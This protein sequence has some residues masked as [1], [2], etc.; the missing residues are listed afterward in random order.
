MPPGRPT[1]YNEEILV[2][3]RAY[4]DG[5]YLTCGDVIPQMAG[6][7]IELDIHRD[8]IYDWCDDPEKQAFSD[9]VAKCLRAQERKLLNGSLTG[10]LNPTIAKLILTKH[11][12][13]E[14]V[15]QEHT[16]ENGGPISH[17]WTVRLVNA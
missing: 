14:R 3:A 1:K 4:V 10:D 11:G 15:Q 9:I 6:L 5:G 16:G 12:Y 2:K 8:T 17:D 7:S 13:S